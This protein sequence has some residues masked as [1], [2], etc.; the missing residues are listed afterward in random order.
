MGDWR[1][2]A[3]WE[4]MQGSH[5]NGSTAAFVQLSGGFYSGFFLTQFLFPVWEGAQPCARAQPGAA[6]PSCASSPCQGWAGWAPAGSVVA[7]WGGT[8]GLALVATQLGQSWA[9]SGSVQGGKSL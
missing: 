4:G 2:T 1:L 8:E 7:L 9:A 6:A 5:L 3:T